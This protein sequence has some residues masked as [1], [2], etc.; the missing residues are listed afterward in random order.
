MSGRLSPFLH[1]GPA[2]MVRLSFG[3]VGAD[4][5][6]LRFR[7]AEQFVY[8]PPQSSLIA[9]AMG[10]AVVFVAAMLSRAVAISSHVEATAVQARRGQVGA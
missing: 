7:V 5:D 2:V 9:A 6:H 1:P 8:V 10:L 3:G 4:L